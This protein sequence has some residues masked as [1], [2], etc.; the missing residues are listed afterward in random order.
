M[1]SRSGNKDLRS[2][3]YL[4]MSPED[5]RALGVF[6]NE[7]VEVNSRYGNAALPVHI[8]KSVQRGQV[9]AT[10]HDQTRW[11]NRVTGPCR[12]PE[13]D[14]PEYKLTAVQVCKFEHDLPA[15]AS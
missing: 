14:T 15:S 3:D 5:A 10:F 6:E 2:T 8:S 11:V 9:F 4:D 13:V 12:D 1:T 7:T